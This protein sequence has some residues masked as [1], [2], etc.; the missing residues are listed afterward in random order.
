[1]AQIWVTR[2]GSRSHKQAGGQPVSDADMGM[3]VH[4][5]FAGGLS[6]RGAQRCGWPPLPAAPMIAAV[7]L[8]FTW[9]PAAPQYEAGREARCC[10]IPSG[11]A[12]AS[13]A[14][15]G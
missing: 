15:R 6:D 12:I 3:S 5:C 10:E 1:M 4:D 2:R 7:L 13:N 11:K 8:R 9:H 14:L